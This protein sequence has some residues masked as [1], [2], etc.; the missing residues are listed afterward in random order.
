VR[1]EGLGKLKYRPHP[2]LEP[3][4]LQE[5][6]IN[7]RRNIGQYEIRGKYRIPQFLPPVLRRRAVESAKNAA[8]KQQYFTQSSSVTCSRKSLYLL[9]WCLKRFS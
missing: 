3:T 8:K 4:L 5:I 6:N 9:F 1:L 2:G 7:Y